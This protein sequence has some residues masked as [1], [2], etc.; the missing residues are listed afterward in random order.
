ML[1]RAVPGHLAAVPSGVWPYNFLFY[2]V[3]NEFTGSVDVGFAS[4]P[5]TRGDLARL[6]VAT[7]QV[8][9]LDA[10]GDPIQDS[11][12]LYDR[13]IPAEGEGEAGHAGHLYRGLFLTASYPMFDSNWCIIAYPFEDGFF[14]MTLADPV[15]LVG[16]EDYDGLNNLP[17]WAVTD[18]EGDTIFLAADASVTVVSGILA[19][20]VATGPGE[21][22]QPEEW[23]TIV[24]V[25]G[26]KVPYDHDG[27]GFMV[28]VAPLG[29]DGPVITG[30]VPTMLNCMGP[31][32]VLALDE[33]LQPTVLGDM[34]GPYLPPEVLIAVDPDGKAVNVVATVFTKE[35]WIAHFEA[36]EVEP[37]GTKVDTR[38]EP[39]LDR[40]ESEG[41]EL[42]GYFPVPAS[43]LVELNGALSER[44]DLAESDVISVA[45]DFNML[46][47]ALMVWDGGEIDGGDVEQPAPEP[48]VVRAHRELVEGTVSS[49]STTYSEAEDPVIRATVDLANGGSKTY[50][51]DPAG[52]ID[53]TEG[54]WPL[55][56]VDDKVKYGLNAAGDIFV[57]IGYEA[58]TPYVV[59][60][61]YTETGDG[62]FSA[63]FDIRGDEVT[64][65]LDAAMPD[66]APAYGEP[67]WIGQYVY[68]EVSSGTGIVDVGASHTFEPDFTCRVLA[69]DAA[70]GTLTLQGPSGVEFF[71]DRTSWSTRST[72]R[73]RRSTSASRAS[74]QAAG[75]STTSA[76]QDTPSSRSPRNR[77]GRPPA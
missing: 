74:S 75:S 39:Y 6:I 63:T 22:D 76:A 3:D 77:K 64:Y 36:S 52:G 38:V 68:V 23:D 25:D 72:M 55:P 59:C 19:D 48:F 70:N 13:F 35:T 41:W 12:I 21:T 69:V 57:P 11:A 49:T 43:C 47:E 18:S 60:R 65:A 30:C 15:H 51:V 44:D 14:E 32:P 24:L 10:D 27:D 26:T 50:V 62:H 71:D 46:F 34:P 45:F 20:L 8:P 66:E 42:F 7:M 37:D 53:G 33:F 61:S 1:V 31:F 2:G 4:L 56:A 28:G 67:D 9:R 40:W 29:G 5:A 16:A 17:V 58:L 54:H 73:A